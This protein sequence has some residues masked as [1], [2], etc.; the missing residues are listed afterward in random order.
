MDVVRSCAAG[1]DEVVADAPGEGNV[2]LV[3]TVHVTDRTAIRQELRLAVI[4]GGG[5]DP[6][7]SRDRAPDALG[8]FVG[9]VAHGDSSRVLLFTVHGRSSSPLEVNVTALW[10]S[11]HRHRR[12]ADL[13][14]VRMS[15]GRSVAGVTL[16]SGR[17]SLTP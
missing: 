13:S 4:P 1:G 11:S 5:G 8:S 17:D 9:I 7:P 15:F 3:S 2:C 16:W 14:E 10:C 6:W 12:V